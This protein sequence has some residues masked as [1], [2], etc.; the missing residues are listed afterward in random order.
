[1]LVDDHAIVRQGYRTL[2]EKQPR[3]EVVAEADDG[4]V[5]YRLY[6]EMQP[7]LVVMD[8]T[9]PQM[10]GMESIR[11]IVR[12]DPRARILVFTMH[13][14]AAYAVQAMR[15]GARGYITKTGTPQALVQAAFDVL[16]GKIALSAD[17][18]HELALSRIADA[19]SVIDELT[20]REF[21]ILRLLL[22]G[23]SID[24]IAGALNLSRKTVANMHYLIKN[25]LGVTS[26]IALVLI[27]LRHGI[28]GENA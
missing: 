26:D 21:E 25:K 5:A 2:L 6:Q 23:Q 22:T 11:R 16:D 8:L 7:D 24:D 10:G 28:L 15:A 1:M 20:P 18:D 4:D 3:I 14:N 27:A 19:G 17:I 12:W 9:L 13:Q